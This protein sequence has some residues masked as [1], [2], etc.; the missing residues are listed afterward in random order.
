MIRL[1]TPFIA[2]P[3]ILAY[4]LLWLLAGEGEER[5]YDRWHY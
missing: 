4:P 2:I 5:P 3:I 1:L